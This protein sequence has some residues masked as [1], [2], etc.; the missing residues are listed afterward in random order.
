SA[1]PSRQMTTTGRGGGRYTRPLTVNGL[2]A[3]TVTVNYAVGEIQNLRN[4]RECRRPNREW[5]PQIHFDFEN[6]DFFRA[7]GFG[8]RD[9]GHAVS[10]AESSA[11]S[12]PMQQKNE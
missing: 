4:P 2:V 11:A 10:Q 6:S 8:F 7:S 1:E 5:C 9:S 12:P 3:G